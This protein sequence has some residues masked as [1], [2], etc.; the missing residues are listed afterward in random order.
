MHV[1]RGGEDDI[2]VGVDVVVRECDE[3]APTPKHLPEEMVSVEA[4][5]EGDVV[6]DD[7]FV[8]AVVEVLDVEHL[9]RAPREVAVAG[10]EEE[11]R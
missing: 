4:V 3:L 2:E 5:G 8:V 11:V 1:A 6:A 7:V 9:R 10:R